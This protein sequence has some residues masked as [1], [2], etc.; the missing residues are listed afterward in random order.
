[1][2][3]GGFGEEKYR[4]I[5]E[6]QNQLLKTLDEKMN[7]KIVNQHIGRALDNYLQSSLLVNGAYSTASQSADKGQSA[8]GHAFAATNLPSV[9]DWAKQEAARTIYLAEDQGL[10]TLIPRLHYQMANHMAYL[11]NEAKLKALEYFWRASASGRLLL[12]ISS[13]K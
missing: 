11:D 10:D 6:S 7:I 3:A 13:T 9:L 5:N 1:M 4:H 8:A 12:A 2:E